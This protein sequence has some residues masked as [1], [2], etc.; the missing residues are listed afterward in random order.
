MAVLGQIWYW[1]LK[2]LGVFSILMV[3]FS[4]VLM[5]RTLRRELRFKVGSVV[6]Q[7]ISPFVVLGAYALFVKLTPP[8]WLVL[9]LFGGGMV[10]GVAWSRSVEMRKSGGYIVSKRSPLY[11]VIWAVTFVLTQALVLFAGNDVAAWG[12]ATLYFSAG[13]ALAM[14]GVLLLRSASIKT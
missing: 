2:G 1:V 10:L 11:I 9:P 3:V 13:L 8:W 12:F 14:N 5:I 6:V 7:A 4:A